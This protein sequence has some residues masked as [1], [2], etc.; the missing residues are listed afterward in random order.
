MFLVTLIYLV[1]QKLTKPNSILILYKKQ[2]IKLKKAMQ[3]FDDFISYPFAETYNFRSYKPT[4][5]LDCVTF[6]KNILTYKYTVILNIHKYDKQ[7][8]LFSH[9]SF[10][11]GN[12][13]M[14]EKNSNKL[15]SHNKQDHFPPSTVK[16]KKIKKF[17]LQYDRAQKDF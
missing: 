8:C 7:T 3:F 17:I 14:L 6:V 13:N 15:S 11:R 12:N 16:I 10:I 5:A 2:E 1:F 4:S 9:A